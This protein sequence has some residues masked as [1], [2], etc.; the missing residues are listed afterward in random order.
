[1]ALPKIS[2]VIP[3]RGRAQILRRC[4]EHIEKQTIADQIEVIVVIDGDD[5]K[6]A[7]MLSSLRWSFPLVC[8]AIPK[9]QQ[10]VARNRGVEKARGDIVLFIGDDIFL[11]PDACERHLLCHGKENFSQG[12]TAVLGHTAW[13]PAV[14]IT[15]IMRWLEKTGWQF[16]YSQIAEH[17]GKF[18]PI[19][20]QHRF[21]YT[22]HISLP[23]LT[24]LQI[25]FHEDTLL[26]G[27]EDIEWGIRLRNAGVRL[28]YEPTAHAFHH[29]HLTLE[30]SLKRMETLGQSARIFAGLHPSFDRV[31][32]GGKRLLYNVLAL[33]PT[34]RGK[35]A[36]AFL[37]G[38]RTGKREN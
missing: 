28:F 33:L 30:D 26:Y 2:I 8:F 27:W 14:G 12:D 4:L 5:P 7:E 1:M 21:T 11:A 17:V 10:G 32:R 22:S 19:E 38:L 36:K 23:R 24:A 25:Q 31:P 35:H 13:D 9:A 29:H 16:G 3:T 34:L 15:P 37:K 20:I 18:L 6:S